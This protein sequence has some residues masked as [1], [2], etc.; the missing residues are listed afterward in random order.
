MYKSGRSGVR[1][2]HAQAMSAAVAMVVGLS[3][4]G[5]SDAGAAKPQA[6][7]PAAVQPSKAAPPPAAGGKPALGLVDDEASGVTGRQVIVAAPAN[8]RV[9]SGVAGEAGNLTQGV[10]AGTYA[11]DVAV[12]PRHGTAVVD[13]TNLVYTSDADYVGPDEFTYQ[14]AGTGKGAGAVSDTA[15]VSITVN[16]TKAPSVHKPKPKTKPKSKSKRK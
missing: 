15:V 4:C 16:A 6:K 1:R 11:L 12:D 9:A 5:G 13:G 3:G 10:G 2:R 14:V 8:D 7:A